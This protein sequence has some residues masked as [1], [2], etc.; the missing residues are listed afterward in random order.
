MI[1]SLSLFSHALAPQDLRRVS[2][3]GTAELSTA[4]AE[5]DKVLIEAQRLERGECLRDVDAFGV[6]RGDR[7]QGAGNCAVRDV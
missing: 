2:V 6:V 4:C 7:H 5:R 1:R 3:W